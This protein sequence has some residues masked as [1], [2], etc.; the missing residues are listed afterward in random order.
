MGVAWGWVTAWVHIMRCWLSAAVAEAG[1]GRESVCVCVCSECMCPGRLHAQE[2]QTKTAQT[3]LI[4]HICRNLAHISYKRLVRSHSRGV[5]SSL[6]RQ[7]W[8]H[9]YREQLGWDSPDSQLAISPRPV[10]HPASQAGRQDENLAWSELL[11]KLEWLAEHDVCVYA[12]I[13][14]ALRGWGREVLG[15]LALPVGW[16]AG[17]PGRV[18]EPS[19]AA[20]PASIALLPCYTERRRRSQCQSCQPQIPTTGN[21]NLH[22]PQTHLFSTQ[23]WLTSQAQQSDWLV[24]IP[25][26]QS[27]PSGWG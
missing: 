26:S 14:F 3:Q 27:G 2:K 15:W 16:L 1:G 23:W 18:D 12:H 6:P 24:P 7:P 10:D 25:A 13:S 5:C 21:H 4:P 17:V 22:M 9:L 19:A 11:N 8:F 20:P